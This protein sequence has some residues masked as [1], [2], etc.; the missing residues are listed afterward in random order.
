MGVQQAD[1]F[2]DP[3]APP[4][5]D[6]SHVVD[7]VRSLARSKAMLAFVLALGI[8]LVALVLSRFL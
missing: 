4:D 2:E 5:T 8:G 7:D 6:L 1:A 3:I